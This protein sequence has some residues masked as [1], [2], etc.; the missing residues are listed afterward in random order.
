MDRLC[1]DSWPLGSMAHKEACAR[2]ADGMEASKRRPWN[3][4]Q[5]MMMLMLLWRWRSRTMTVEMG[6]RQRRSSVVVG[7]RI[8]SAGVVGG[9][10]DSCCLFVNAVSRGGW[11]DDVR[12][13]S[14]ETK[15]GDGVRHLIGKKLCDRGCG[16]QR[17]VDVQGVIPMSTVELVS[18]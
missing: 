3:M 11:G 9:Y 14:S 18:K 1:E 17:E 6:S 7:Q 16:K 8:G 10:S 5:L 2:R 12:C 13:S 15:I 4:N